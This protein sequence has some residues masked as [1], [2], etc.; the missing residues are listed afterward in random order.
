[1]LLLASRRR[2]VSSLPTIVLLAATIAAGLGAR[3]LAPTTGLATTP[4]VTEEMLLG[5]VFATIPPDVSWVGIDRVTLAPGAVRPVGKTENEGVG[6]WLYRV[7]SGA[8]TVVADGPMAVRRA[9]APQAGVV[10]PGVAATLHPGD[11]GS[12]ASS[13]GALWRNSTNQPTTVLEAA[14]TARTDMGDPNG[15]NTVTLVGDC[16]SHPLTIPDQ[17]VAIGLRRVTLPT[18]ATLAAARIAGLTAFAVDAGALTVDDAGGAGSAP[19]SFTIRTGDGRT[20]GGFGYRE[21]PAGWVFRNAARAPV[22]LLVLTVT[23]ADPLLTPRG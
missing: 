8:L 6:P 1:M 3:T 12:T 7:E 11:R 21:V 10:G 19:G 9:G 5:G 17:P 16:S 2:V 4:D 18:G 13:V 20:F 22:Q 23:P 14:I 15:V